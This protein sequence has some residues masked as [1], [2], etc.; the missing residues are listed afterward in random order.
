V[1]FINIY[2][3]VSIIITVDGSTR[4]DEKHRGLAKYIRNK[5]QE[6]YLFSHFSSQ[7]LI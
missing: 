1:Y 4:I 5:E 3:Y 6:V 2:F 7:S